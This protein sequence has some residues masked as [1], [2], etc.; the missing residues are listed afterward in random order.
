MRGFEIVW[1]KVSIIWL[2]YNSSKIMPIVLKSLESIV[3]LDYPSDRYELIVVDNGS[4]DG[5]FEKIK[6]FIERENGL[7]KK[8]IKLSKNLGFTGGNNIGFMARDRESEY[9]LLINNDTILFQDGLRTLIEYIE[10]ISNNNVASLQGVV[11]RY[12]TRH[13]DTAG[14]YMDELLRT[15]A[16]GQLH[17]YPWILRKPIHVTYVAGCCALYRVKSV[18]KCIGDKL[19][20][21]EFFGHADD[22]VLGLLMWNCGY[23]AVAIPKAVASHARGLT[24]GRGKNPFLI[25]LLERNRVALSIITNTKYRH[26]IFSHIL[27]GAIVS[28][29]RTDPK[30]LIQVRMRAL[31]DGI[32][33]GKKLKSRGLFINLYKAPL[34]RIPLRDI[35]IYFT[36]R[37]II[38]R[39][40]ENWFI[41]NLSFLTVE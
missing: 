13:I 17:E 8:I 7:K 2:N 34:I 30:N 5:S 29:L 3:N 33:L 38:V 21:D 31:Y 18:L 28:T 6:E 35:G 11:L 16:L 40:F 4:T 41:K 25:Y 19:F 26:V 1:P 39:Y 14:E 15:H 9:V 20:I 36:T 22:N 12:G 27:R 37:H 24:F 23:R 10:N 32:K